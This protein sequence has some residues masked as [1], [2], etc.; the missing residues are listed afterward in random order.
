[1]PKA[2]SVDM[3][4]NSLKNRYYPVDL[5]DNT[6][7]RV[8]YLVELTLNTWQVRFYRYPYYFDVLL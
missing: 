7:Y 4:A 1:M 8:S 6:E 3:I 5:M 2:Y